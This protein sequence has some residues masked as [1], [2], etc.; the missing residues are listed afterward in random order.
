MTRQWFEY[1]I[2]QVDGHAR[3]GTFQTPHGGI[4]TPVFAPVGTQATVKSVT[5]AQLEEIG[6]SLVLANTYHLYLRPGENLVAELGGLH[7]I[8]ELATTNPYGFRWISG[9]F[10]LRYPK[11]G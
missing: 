8:H 7:Q 2:E 3:V 5:P 11:S 9:I 6:A 4:S 10:T 1:K